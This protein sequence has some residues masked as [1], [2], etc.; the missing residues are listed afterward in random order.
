MRK[1]VLPF[2]IFSRVFHGIRANTRKLKNLCSLGLYQHLSI[3]EKPAEEL[4]DE[5]GNKIPNPHY[6][7]WITNDGLLTS[8]LLRTIKED[9]LS[10]VIDEAD[11][12]YEVW[13]SLEQQLLPVT[14]EKKDNLKK[15]L[16]GIKKGSRSIDEYLKDFKYTCDNLPAIKKPSFDLDKVFQ[17]ARG[18]GNQ[19]MNF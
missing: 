15:K 1:S 14:V 3:S 13:T 7:L 9:I 11:T 12:A 19:Y 8:W 16:I 17:F 2:I 10:M 18:L 4:A 6:H 5:E